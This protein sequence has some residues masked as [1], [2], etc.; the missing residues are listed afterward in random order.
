MKFTVRTFV[1][2][3]ALSSVAGL[4]LADEA[5]EK[6][7]KARQ[8]L[9]QLYS[10]N[11]GALGAMAK[12]AVPY[13]AKT[14]SVHANNLMHATMIEHVGLWPEGTHSDAYGD[15]TAALEKIWSTYPAIVEKNEALTAAA[16]KMAEEA[17]NGLEAVKANLGEVGK[18]CKGCHD[19][20]RK[21]DK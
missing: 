15:K 5:G 8:S 12:E 16:K 13:D 19:D 14:A 7:I 9:M 10:F 3:L 2:T 20:F 17:G 18:T 1:C 11:L 6:A 4:A 21:S